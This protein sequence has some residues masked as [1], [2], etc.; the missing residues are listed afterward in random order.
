M[1]VIM[2]LIGQISFLQTVFK[3]LPV[4]ATVCVCVGGGGLGACVC[5]GLCVWGGGAG[6][7]CMGDTTS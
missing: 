2:L 5:G 7:L 3:C 1:L 6:G 4:S